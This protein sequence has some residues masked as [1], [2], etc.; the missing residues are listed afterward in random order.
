MISVSLLPQFSRDSQQQTDIGFMKQKERIMKKENLSD[1]FGEAEDILKKAIQEAD[2]L[3]RDNPNLFRDIPMN[4]MSVRQALE[5]DN[6][7]EN[8]RNEMGERET[9]KLFSLLYAAIME[10]NSAGAG[11]LFDRYGKEEIETMYNHYS[12][13]GA[14]LFCEAI[15][16]MRGFIKEKLGETYSDDEFFQL[17]DTKE[18]VAIDRGITLRYEEMCE[19]MEQALIAFVRYNIEQ[20]ENNMGKVVNSTHE[21]ETD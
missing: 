6:P 3:F 4:K 18:Y 10:V 8:I 14:G 21:S 9:Q 17:C 12:Y 13:F 5:S 19:E 20:L 15:D 1:E 11:I 16:K 7:L 2:S